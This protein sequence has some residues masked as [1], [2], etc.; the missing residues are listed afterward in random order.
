MK[1]N[2]VTGY[3]FPKAEWETARLVLMHTPGEEVYCGA[4]H[5]A[6]ALYEHYM[7]ARAAARE[8]RGYVEWLRGETDAEVMT[9]REILEGTETGELREFASR[10]LTYSVRV[11]AAEE[12]AAAEE[13]RR[14]TLEQMTKE[15][16]IRVILLRPT[17]HL[18]RSVRN[19]GWRAEYALRPLMNLFYMRDQM[20]CTP[21]GPV[22]GRMN[23]EQRADEADVAAFCLR[24]LGIEAVHRIGDEGAYLEGGDYIPFGDR[25]FIGV[26]LRTTQ[27]AVEEMMREDVMG[28][29]C[30]VVVRDRKCKQN[31]MHLDTYFNVIDRDLATLGANRLKAERGSD[32]WLTADVY[33]RD[34]GRGYRMTEEGV[35]F[36][37]YL[38]REG[39]EIIPINL[40]D[41]LR[42]GNNY[43]TVS[44][45]RIVGV[46][47]QS[48]ELRRMLAERGVRT[49]WLDLSELTHGYGAAHCMT[50]VIRRG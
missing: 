10:F 18:R 5:P 24:Q 48:E 15:E 43:L 2:G 17:L 49:D 36:V 7:D 46:A 45:R 40:R 26:G 1:S 16:L 20:I 44:A 50:Q 6:A 4:M 30:V 27:E 25:A 35:P 14:E 13:Y 37:E 23:S 39:V 22:I 12:R 47:G 31:Q 32:E 9:V 42:Y 34:G 41:E 11:L 38:R 21:R 3:G 28:H 29:E 8:H 33:E 19:T